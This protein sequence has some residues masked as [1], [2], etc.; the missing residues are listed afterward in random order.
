MLRYSASTIACACATFAPTSATSAFFCSTFRPKVYLLH[1]GA[2][3]ERLPA[4]P[5]RWFDCSDLRS[6]SQLHTAA[7]LGFRRHDVYSRLRVRHLRR[8]RKRVAY[9]RQNKTWELPPCTAATRHPLT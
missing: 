1:S 2:P 3:D 7:K 9:R 5:V 6:G 8:T 4:R